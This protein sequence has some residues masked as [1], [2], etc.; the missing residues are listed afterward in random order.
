MENGIPSKR[1]QNRLHSND[2]FDFINSI[3]NSNCCFSTFLSPRQP[4]SS[5]LAIT[6]TIDKRI[7]LCL[8]LLKEIS[9]EDSRFKKNPLSY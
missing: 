2:P 3:N 4:K 7:E 6:L 9:E 1:D 8:L 5:Q